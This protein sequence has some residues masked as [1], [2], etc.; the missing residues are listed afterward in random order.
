MEFLIVLGSGVSLLGLAFLI[1]IAIT[2]QREHGTPNWPSVKGEVLESKVV[3]FE[4]ETPEGIERTFTPLVKYRYTVGER[5]FTSADLNFLPDSTA[6]YRVGAKAEAVVARYPAGSPV[7][8]FYN[9]STPGQAVLEIPRPAA[10]NA[11]LFYGI[12]NLVVGAAIIA[13]GIVLLPR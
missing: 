10:H 13:L 7:S 1:W 6:T 11:I 12:T 9:P 5:S 4:R 2:K 8:V 3:A